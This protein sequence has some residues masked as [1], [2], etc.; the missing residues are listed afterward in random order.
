MFFVVHYQLCLDPNFLESQ[1]ILEMFE[2]KFSP[3]SF[4][5][6]WFEEAEWKRKLLIAKG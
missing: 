6:I 5:D 4:S 3:S 2:I 1:A